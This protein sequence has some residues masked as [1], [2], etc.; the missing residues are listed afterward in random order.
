MNP[1]ELREL[2]DDIA[3]NGLREPVTLTPDGLLL[4]GRNR[5]LAC[6]IARIEPM[7]VTYDGNPELFSLSKNKHRRHMTVDQIAMVTV[8]LATMTH[9]GDRRSVNFKTSNEGLKVA[10]AAAAAGVSKTAIESA[11]VV[12]KERMPE[13]IKAVESG[14]VKLRKTADAIRA[15]KRASAEPDRPS[16]EPVTPF[17]NHMLIRTSPRRSSA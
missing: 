17:A 1:E 4:D 15:R 8:K 11:K 6:D 16:H 7:T 12:L 10:E 5:A 3:A 9:G 14:E 2:A 13:E